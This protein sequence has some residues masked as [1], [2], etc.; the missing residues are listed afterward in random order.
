MIRIAQIKYHPGTEGESIYNQAVLWMYYDYLKYLYK[1]NNQGINV[2]TVYASRL[3]FYDP[4]DDNYDIAHILQNA[5]L[6]GETNNTCKE[7][8]II[9]KIRELPAQFSD[10]PE[11]RSAFCQCSSFH[12]I[13]MNRQQL[14]EEMKNNILPHYFPTQTNVDLIYGALIAKIVDYG[15]KKDPITKRSLIDYI[16]DVELRE[17]Q[18]FKQLIIESIYYLSAKRL[19]SEVSE[20]ED[21]ELTNKYSKIGEKIYDFIKFKFEKPEYRKSFL[22]TII[23]EGIPDYISDTRQEWETYLRCENQVYDFIVRL[24][25]IVFTYEVITGVDV[26]IEQWFIIDNSS[27]IFDY[28]DDLRGKGILLSKYIGDNYYNSI[29]KIARKYEEAEITPDVW[30]YCRAE[31]LESQNSALLE[32]GKNWR[33][34]RQDITKPLAEKFALDR[35]RK[36]FWLECML[37]L[38]RDEFDCIDRVCHIFERGCVFNE[39]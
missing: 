14:V 9:E 20:I 4:S 25:K 2:N 34:Y 13:T 3:F 37:C 39:R 26:I 38:K 28:P 32:Y 23:P 35:T 22:N 24:A 15:R 33:E 18:I 30:Y 17:N 21:I 19:L 27:W 1:K 11:N 12:R 6:K 31:S 29:A 8:K 36:I 10:N 16:N 5:W 7:A